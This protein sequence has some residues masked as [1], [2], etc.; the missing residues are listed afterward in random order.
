MKTCIPVVAHAHASGVEV[1][2]GTV[3]GGLVLVVETGQ[4]RRVILQVGQRDGRPEVKVRTIVRCALNHLVLGWTQ[5]M[6]RGCVSPRQVDDTADTF[7]TAT[8][9]RLSAERSVRLV[10]F[11]QQLFESSS[12]LHFGH[13]VFGRQGGRYSR[14]GRVQMGQLTPGPVSH[15]AEAA[16]EHQVEEE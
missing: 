10:D 16:N 2:T 9:S 14:T 4:H 1:L 11:D 12:F 6:A 3:S 8:T 15:V 7:G 5:R 13:V